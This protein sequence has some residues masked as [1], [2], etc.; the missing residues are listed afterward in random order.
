MAKPWERDWSQSGVQAA[1]VVAAAVK[2]WERDWSNAAPVAP[3]VESAPAEHHG[4]AAVLGDIAAG[5]GNGAA[6]IGS[7]LLTPI[8]YVAHK[9]GVENALFPAD[10]RAAVTQTL[11]DMGA[12]PHSL[13]YKGGEIGAEIAGTA[14]VGGALAK[15]AAAIPRLAQAAP[16][17]IESLKTGGIALGEHG[18]NPLANIA[19]RLAGGTAMGGISAGMIDPKTA[20]EGGVMGAA[21]APV[22]LGAGKTLQFGRELLAPMEARTGKIIHAAA[23]ADPTALAQ[24]IRAGNTS[25]VEGFVPTTAQTVKNAGLSQLQRTATNQGYVPL[26]E[27]HAVN[28]NALVAALEAMQP[29]AAGIDSVTARG[30]AGQV[31]AEHYHA[32][33][34]DLKAAEAGAWNS[35]LLDGLKFNLPKDE[36]STLLNERYPGIIA[37]DMPQ[38]FKKI[39]AAG[40]SIISHNELKALRTS[41][42]DMGYDTNLRGNDQGTA[43]A[44]RDIL[45][46]LYDKAAAAGEAKF[47]PTGKGEHGAIYGGLAGDPENA[48]A[49]LLRMKSGEVPNAVTHPDVPG[50]KVGLVYGV[51]PN[52]SAE[53]YGV[54]KLAQKHP[55]SLQNLQAFLSPMRADMERSG[56]N[57]L[58]M[59][60]PEDD[61]RGIVS[62]THF[63]NPSNPWL[64]TAYEKPNP[65][66]GGV[67]VAPSTRIDT[68]GLAHE[69]D[70]ARFISNPPETV[71]TTNLDNL[72]GVKNFNP[73]LAIA[74]NGK[75]IDTSI[76]DKGGNHDLTS[77][78]S[79][80]EQI[81]K[82]QALFDLPHAP[83]VPPRDVRAY[84]A[85]LMTPEQKA[86]RDAANF[87][88][89][90]RIN[91]FETGPIRGLL[92]KG[93]D[94]LPKKQGAEAFDVLFNSRASQKADIGALAN[95]FPG[96]EPVWN[97]MR[98]AAL[99]DLLEKTVL[100]GGNLS[101]DKL[102]KYVASRRDAIDG[103]FSAEQNQ[104]LGKVKNEL[105]RAF[106]AEN[107]G[108]ATGSNTAQN[109]TG[110]ALID[111]PAMD[112]LASLFSLKGAAPV[113]YA[114][115]GWRNSL[116]SQN[117]QDL[118]NA[119]VHPQVAADSLDAWAKLLEPNALQRGMPALPRVATP[120]L[121]NL[122]NSATN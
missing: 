99:S 15:G 37:G 60:T 84:S 83:V 107:A 113:K 45:T 42:G 98:Q 118:G 108:R 38:E 31:L 40:D 53:G 62:L 52:A 41:L 112:A 57:K 7:T 68:A 86:I 54:A 96:N 51:E 75:T 122:V 71:S 92:D 93:A 80:D 13:A 63:N 34:G 10:R 17:L 23:Q 27:R 78:T 19:T 56:K 28:N 58:V 43:R 61:K 30:N 44:L 49:H 18:L 88:T 3:V 74:G 116:I 2:P 73:Q 67:Q 9:L 101:H 105:A 32:Q 36:I 117:K 119:M 35:P 103:L 81:R 65:A 6:N 59:R 97:A 50:G 48:I 102:S 14:G 109:L 70:T 11:A 91:R 29:G 20:G 90:T 46:G 69:D 120:L 22:A 95:T 8:D 106:M 104:T 114:L 111:H 39:A 82:M 89:Q 94:G 12:D 121:V 1:P 5:A 79:I 72:T 64:L 87:L 55:E 16:A 77:A 26:A 4:I 24:Q 66:L 33:R 100:Q 110:N 76:V 25:S 47:T 115:N 21:L 85:G